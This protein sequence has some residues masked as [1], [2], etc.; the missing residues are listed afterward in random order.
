MGMAAVADLDPYQLP[1]PLM[2]Q[3]QSFVLQLPGGFSGDI[4][5]NVGAFMSNGTQSCLVATG[6]ATS[7]M[8]NGPNDTMTVGLMAATDTQCTGTKVLLTSASPA[9]GSTDGGDTITLNGWGFK[10]G[11]KVYF[12]TIAAPTVKYVSAAQLQV[13]TPTKAGLFGLTP[14]KVVNPDNGSATRGDLFRFY[15]KTVNFTPLLF[16]QTNATYTDVDGFAFGLFNTKTTLDAAVVTPMNDYVRLVFT[17]NATTIT[18]S[19]FTLAPGSLPTGLATADFNKD[20]NLDLVFNT[21]GTAPPT[22]TILLNDGMGNL[23]PG[24]SSPVGNQPDA[25]VIGDFNL[26]GFP[27]VAVA[28]RMDSSVTFLMGDQKGGFQKSPQTITIKGSIN[29]S[30]IAVLDFNHDGQPDLLVGDY[31]SGNIY[32]LQNSGGNFATL[33]QVGPYGIPGSSRII[34][35]ASADINGDGISDIIASDGGPTTT[36]VTVIENH[37]GANILPYQVTT[38]QSPQIVWV[39]DMNG[40]G[41]PDL[42]VPSEAA[43][44][45]DVILNLGGKGFQGAT[46]QSFSSVCMNPIQ[47]A[48]YDIDH[49]GRPDIGALCS[50]GTGGVGLLFNHSGM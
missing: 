20:G 15:A 11:L 17:T 10:P 39:V 38:E 26:D 24:G 33:Q 16:P 43:S 21:Q 7:M 27:D 3:T 36:H 41:Y 42:V 50:G 46:Y 1:Q 30:S 19:D 44:T 8:F 13:V 6:T 48:I 23:T 32:I 5:V 12:G 25:M 37:L 18:H 40:D 4:T 47:I 14:I 45:V 9:L 22:T 29:P 34:G 28:N 35:V 31:N 49:D 2:T